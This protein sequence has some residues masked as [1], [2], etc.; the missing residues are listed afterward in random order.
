[1]DKFD[2]VILV[3]HCLKEVL[4]SDAT[5]KREILQRV[6]NNSSGDAMYL[7]R[8]FCS[9]FGF[10]IQD[11]LLL[12]LQTVIKTWNPQLNISN[13]N[14]RKEL[15]IQEDEVN[16]LNTK[17]NAIVAK[18]SDKV[19]LKNCIASIYSQVNFYY[20]EVFIILMDLIED[21]NIEHRN[22]FCFLQNYTRSGQPT[23][24]E[25]DAWMHHNPECTSLPPIAEWR[26]PFLPKVELWTLISKNL[27]SC[28]LI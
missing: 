14:G 9:D 3:Y 27:F 4:T 21:E 8:D 2:F 16:E 12:Y 18:V 20:Y 11:C 10:D 25:H 23:K 19:A 26:L 17:C 22:Y 5:T 7:L 13:L 6:M 1:M 28:Y 24:V 15:R